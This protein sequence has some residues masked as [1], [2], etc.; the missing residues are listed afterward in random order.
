MKIHIQV[1]KRNKVWSCKDL[2]SQDACQCCQL[3]HIKGAE[4]TCS[5]QLLAKHTL[6]VRQLGFKPL[7]PC[8]TH[9]HTPR[10]SQCQCGPALVMVDIRELSISPTPPLKK[11]S[12]FS[13]R[14]HKLYV[15]PIKIL[16]GIAQNL[17]TI[18]FNSSAKIIQKY[19]RSGMKVTDF[20]YQTS[21]PCSEQE[22]QYN[23]N[24][25]DS[26]HL[27]KDKLPEDTEENLN[28]NSSIMK[29]SVY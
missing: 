9:T 1:L 24:Q 18:P 16:L 4:S 20:A 27:E 15:I 6:G 13:K 11:R 3:S 25:T 7:N 14:D 5:P 21:I 10:G 22:D 8:H 28:A 19:E 2:S 26:I 17:I 23:R 29:I 12:T